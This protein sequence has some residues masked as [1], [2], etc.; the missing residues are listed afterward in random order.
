MFHIMIVHSLFK[1]LNF[2]LKF[3]K[4]FISARKYTFLHKNIYNSTQTKS[5][6]SKKPKATT[7]SLK[8]K[9]FSKTKP[10]ADDKSDR[11]RKNS[12]SQVTGSSSIRIK[13]AT[14]TL[15]QLRPQL[16]SF[17]LLG[18]RSFLQTIFHSAG[19]NQVRVM[20]NVKC[21]QRVQSLSLH[22]ISLLCREG[23]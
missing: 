18:P 17:L 9:R 7:C 22:E 1:Y 13:P 4:S 8:P 19:S 20:A 11:S 10:I 3:N 14:Y 6:I 15:P 23:E 2:V 21:R 5:T 16:Y 12:K